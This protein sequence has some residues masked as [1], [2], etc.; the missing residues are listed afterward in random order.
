[1]KC[2]AVQEK[3]QLDLISKSNV[4]LHEK[5]KKDLLADPSITVPW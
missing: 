1:M 2:N 4:K 5:E 3:E